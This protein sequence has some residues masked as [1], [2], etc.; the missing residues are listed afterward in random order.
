MRRK[1]SRRRRNR[2]KSPTPSRRRPGKTAPAEDATR[3]LLQAG[4]F[5]TP[6]DADAMRARLAL[7]GLDAKVYPIE[8]GGAT[9]YRVRVGPYGSIDDI[10]RIRKLMAENSIEAQVVRLK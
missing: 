8:Q 9:L 6:V 10:N 1:P 7:L 2:R 3:Y 4:A 5:K